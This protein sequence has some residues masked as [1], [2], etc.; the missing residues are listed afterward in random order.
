MRATLIYGER[1]IRLEEVPDPILSTGGDAIVRVV[2]ACVCGSDL[3]PYRGVQPTDEPHRIGHEFVGVVEEIGADVTTIKVGD[4][5][6]APFYDCDNTCINCRN[7]VST[8]CL[9]GGW[10]GA[11]DQLGGFADGAQGERVRVPHADGSL[12]ATPSMPTD[13][14][15]P[16]LLTLADVMGTGHHAAVSAGVTPGSTVVVVGDGA[17]GL[18]AIIAAKRLGASRIVA[19]SRHADRQAVAREFGATDIVEERGAA[20]VAKIHEMFDGIGADFVLECV[21][22]KESM[23][24]AIESA[25]PG[26]M[27]GY[28]GVPTGGPLAVRPLFGRNVGLNGGVA[29]IRGYVEELLP[30]VLSGAINPGRVFDLEL[31]LAEVAEAYA[32]MDERRAI[33][34]LLRP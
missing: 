16:G 29:S 20:G 9:H 33:K 27:V 5:V 32:A 18:C 15:V 14:Q 23:E 13:A 4:F 19:M 30:E 17:V 24:Q 31:P 12:V 22:T 7:G 1:D 25:R 6:I 10:W 21:G 3:W 11:D 2:A 34:V 28:V 8:S 26:G